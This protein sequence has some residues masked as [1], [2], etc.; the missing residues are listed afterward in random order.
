MKLLILLALFC[1]SLAGHAQSLTYDE[2]LYA[3]PRSKYMPSKEDM[4]R[5]IAETEAEEIQKVQHITA[6]QFSETVRKHGG[7]GHGGSYINIP[8]TNKDMIA[9]AA[10]TS[11]GLI[12]FKNDQ[13]IMDY[14]QEHRDD[15]PQ[16]VEDFGNFIGSRGGNAAIMAGSYFLG[17]VLKDNKLKKVGIISV[18][19]GVATA[20]VTEAFKKT[21]GRA[22]PREGQGPY[23]FYGEGK[24]F[25]S[26]HTSSIFSIATVFA[27]VYGKENP[28][29]PWIAYGVATVTA[30]ARMS[31]HAHW[32]SDVLT[33]AIAG[34]LVTKVVYHY[35]NKKFVDKKGNEYLSFYPSY[36]PKTKGVNVMV[37]WI[38]KAWRR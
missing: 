21:Y 33:G 34:Y 26:G 23:S 37:N 22:R 6:P 3:A 25:F 12:I 24:S 20:L 8:V 18:A 32:G 5:I 14:V 31:S 36:D 29:V 11:L 30:Y 16:S 7:L 15:V 9:L 2:D 1:S 27:E 35:L 10:A 17:V 4:K 38:P 13:E 19:A 28:V